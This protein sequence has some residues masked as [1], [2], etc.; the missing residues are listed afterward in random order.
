MASQR[1]DI[2]IANSKNTAGRIQK[3]YRR[4]SQIIYPS[5][6]VERFQ[7]SPNPSLVRRGIEQPLSPF[8]KKVPPLT[9][10]RLGGVYYIIISALT[11][12]KKLDIAIEA[13]NKMPEKKPQNSMKWKF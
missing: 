4:D 8:N 5:V 1:V 10:G 13:F 9:K 2:V 12:F 6:E 7:T 3:Y 11:E